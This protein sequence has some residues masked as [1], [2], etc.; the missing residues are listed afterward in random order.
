MISVRPCTNPQSLLADWFTIFVQFPLMISPSSTPVIV[1]QY[2]F[3][4]PHVKSLKNMEA[5]VW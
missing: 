4:W 3:S 1:P 2:D 5:I